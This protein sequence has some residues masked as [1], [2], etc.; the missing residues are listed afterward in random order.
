MT[1]KRKK[2]LFLL[3]ILLTCAVLIYIL[4][5]STAVKNHLVNRM[6]R[7]VPDAQ[8]SIGSLKLRFPP[9][10]SLKDIVISRNGAVLFGADSLVLFP[11]WRSLLSNTKTIGFRGQAYNGSISGTA[12][13]ARGKDSDQWTVNGVL[14]DIRLEQIAALQEKIDV[15]L[16]G[17]L[18]GSFQ[19]D[20]VSA[21][22]AAGMGSFVI[23]DCGIIPAVPFYD[24]DRLDFS[25]ID[26]DIVLANNRI[27]LNH[28]DFQGSELSASMSGRIILASPADQSDVK[29]DIYV[30][31]RRAFLSKLGPIFSENLISSLLSD[32]NGFSFNLSGSLGSPGFALGTGS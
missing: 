6:N 7:E 2:I 22:H 9:A 12:S 28:S 19:L 14:S 17:T 20:E 21:E 4:F 26:A 32:N 25:R 16:I 5:P 24:V 18:S 1:R 29:L 15:E 27:E 13:P 8:V 10:L 23:T 30:T 11:K 31:P 3:Y